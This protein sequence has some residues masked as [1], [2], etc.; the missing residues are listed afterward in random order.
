VVLESYFDGA[1]GPNRDCLTLAT[2]CGT[3]EQWTELTSEWNEV[4]ARHGANFLHA[5]DAVSLQNDFHRDKGWSKVSVDALILDCVG[6]IARHL[7]VP[8]PFTNIARPGL[9]VVT[10]TIPLEDYRRARKALSTLPNS[11]ADICTSES[12]GFCFRWGRRIGADTY[13]LY[14]DQG[15]RFYGHVYDRKHNKKSK[16]AIAAMKDVVCLCESNMRS[17]PAIQLADLFAWCITHNHAVTREWHDRLHGLPW[18]SLYLDYNY[19][20]NPKPGALEQTS[21]WDLPSRKAYP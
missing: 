8:G 16:K 5:T 13:K 9:H 17:V 12:L 7:S 3:T 10:L 21:A 2:A 14:F 19:L 11:V 6:V 1:A 18:Y 4:L 20:L 15:E